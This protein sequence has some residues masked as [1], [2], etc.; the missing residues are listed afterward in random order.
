VFAARDEQPVA[1]PLADLAEGNPRA[2]CPLLPS[3]PS[4]DV[5]RDGEIDSPLAG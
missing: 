4:P 3:S 1:I 2:Q 5:P